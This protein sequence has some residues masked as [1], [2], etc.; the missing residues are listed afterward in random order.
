MILLIILIFA[1]LV[2]FS[3]CACIVAKDADEA[4]EKIKIKR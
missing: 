3:F 1:F 4:I 2:I